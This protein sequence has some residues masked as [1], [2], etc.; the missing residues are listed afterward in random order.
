MHKEN[1][2]LALHGAHFQWGSLYPSLGEQLLAECHD[3]CKLV[4]GGEWFESQRCRGWCKALV[5]ALVK[6]RG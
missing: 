1:T 4:N 3:Y 6:F 5:L 2:P